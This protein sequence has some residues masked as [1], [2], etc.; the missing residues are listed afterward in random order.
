MLSLIARS[1]PRH[2]PSPT[3]ALR[4][5]SSS[6][7]AR[8]AVPIETKPLNKEFKIYRWVPLSLLL[9]TSLYSVHRFSFLQNPDEPQNSPQL[10]SYTI[11]LNE[12]GPMVGTHSLSARLHSGPSYILRFLMHSSKSRMKLTR[13][14]LSAA[15]V[16]RVSAVLAL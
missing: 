9:S 6:A 16:E 13:H 8:Q 3:L 11:N 10:Q 2:L 1:S 14:S 7:L 4:S 5:F 12:C 15:H